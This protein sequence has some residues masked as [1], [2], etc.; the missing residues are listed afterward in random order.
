M[1][2]EGRRSTIQVMNVSEED[3]VLHRGEFIG[4][5]EQVTVVDN[6]G[7]ALKPAGGEKVFSEAAATPTGR[8]VEEP[9]LG[10]GCDDEHIQVVIENLPA[11]LDLDQRT[12]AK[13]FIRDRAGLFSKLDYDIG[14]TNL[15]QHVI[16]SGMHR[17]FKQPL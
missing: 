13:T 7:E 11:E 3:F 16:D 4:E 5:A 12:T 9:D 8:P 2:D 14:R 6:E 17:P 15:V 10:E 1:R